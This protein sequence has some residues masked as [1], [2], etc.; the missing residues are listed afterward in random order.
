MTRAKPPATNPS[1]ASHWPRTCAPKTAGESRNTDRHG[2]FLNRSR[3]DGLG[4]ANR[5]QKEA[6]GPSFFL[7][8]LGKRQEERPHCSDP[9]VFHDKRNRCLGVS[10]VTAPP[11]YAG[12]RGSR[13]AG[14]RRWGLSRLARRCANPLH[15]LAHHAI[16]DDG[17]VHGPWRC[18]IEGRSPSAPD[19]LRPL[20]VA[21]SGESLCRG[22]NG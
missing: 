9:A 18:G 10:P 4:V 22:G 6:R 17:S 2:L 16:V 12:E 13:T 14:R 8:R 3:A 5:G 1:G 11:L 15:P 21:G 20:V 19:L 7:A